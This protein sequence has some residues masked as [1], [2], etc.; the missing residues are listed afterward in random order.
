MTSRALL[1]WVEQTVGASIAACERLT[2]GITSN[3]HRVTIG[4]AAY[5]LRS[6]DDPM[7]E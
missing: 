6:W 7:P 5:V 4:D 1:G 2:G 3:V